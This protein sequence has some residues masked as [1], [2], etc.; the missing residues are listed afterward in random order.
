[1]RR[2]RSGVDGVGR[3]KE[4]LLVGG[5]IRIYTGA[6]AWRSRGV[7]GLVIWPGKSPRRTVFQF[8]PQ[9]W[10]GGPVRLG[11]PEGFSVSASKL[12]VAPDAVGRPGGF[13][14]LGLK[15]RSGVRRGRTARRV[16]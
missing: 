9:N 4:G 5:R 8:G 3:V 12:R 1:M 6:S 7:Q 15:T 2:H 11:S 16:W 13:P 10:S 14:G